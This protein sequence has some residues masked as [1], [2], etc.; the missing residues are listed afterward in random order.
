MVNTNEKLR[1]LIQESNKVTATVRKLEDR[2]QDE[3]DLI[4]LQ[5]NLQQKMISIQEK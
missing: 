4:A 1:K 5:K 3:V 2:L